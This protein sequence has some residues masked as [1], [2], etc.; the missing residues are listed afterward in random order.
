VRSTFLLTAFPEIVG[1]APILS[2]ASVMVQPDSPLAIVRLDLSRMQLSAGRGWY[3]TGGQ[4]TVDVKDLS[5]RIL[6]DAR[7]SVRASFVSG[8]GGGSDLASADLSDQANRP[9]SS[10]RRGPEEGTTEPPPV[11]R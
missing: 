8:T 1:E 6:I 4:Y 9:G 7:I 3:T 2:R 11:M 10:G 5:D